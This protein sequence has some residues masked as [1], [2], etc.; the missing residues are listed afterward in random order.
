MF[1]RKLGCNGFNSC[2][3]NLMVDR[4][5]PVG[6]ITENGFSMICL[7]RKVISLCREM[8]TKKE[9]LKKEK[10]ILIGEDQVPGFEICL[11]IP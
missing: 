5:A 2:E 8:T 1:E 10:L 6:G 4:K 7:R 3:T 9:K 11:R